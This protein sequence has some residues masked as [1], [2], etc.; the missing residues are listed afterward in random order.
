MAETLAERL[1]RGHRA[2]PQGRRAAGHHPGRAAAAA[3]GP[4]RAS[5]GGA[6]M[7]E[8]TQVTSRG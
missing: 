2:R 7:S 1:R 6:G 5:G 3:P 4:V 8:S